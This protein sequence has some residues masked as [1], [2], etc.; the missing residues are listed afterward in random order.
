[1]DTVVHTGQQYALVPQGD[2]G[3]GKAGAGLA[4]FVGQF[5]GMVKVGVAPYRMIFFDHVAQFRRD[6]L[7]ADHRRPGAETDNLHVFDGP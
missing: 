4:G 1:M 3:V 6:P 5:V 7:G 2:T